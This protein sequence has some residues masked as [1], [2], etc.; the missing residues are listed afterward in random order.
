MKPVE[1]VADGTKYWLSLPDAEQDYIQKTI[2]STQ[3]AY[4]EAMLID[5]ADFIEPG[6]LVLDIG[7]N[8]GN[9][10]LYLSCVAGAE[11]HAFEPDGELCGVIRTSASLN[12]VDGL[13][14]VHEV[15]VGD[16]RGFG[17]LVQ[18]SENNRG[19][20]RLERVSSEDG[21][22]TI[23]RLDDLEF[24]KPV[25]VMKIDVEGM[26]TEVLKGA[27]KLVER[28]RPDIYVECQTRQDFERI[29]RWLIELDY[30]YISTFN[31]T[32]THRF[33]SSSSSHAEDRFEQIVKQQVA[34]TYYDQQLISHLRKNLTEANLKYRGAT[35]QLPPSMNRCA[36]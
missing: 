35:A 32:P 14:T 17:R 20:Q 6:D 33:G 27:R 24:S 29:H 18:T 22:T 11:V 34:A 16:A 31:A 4:E 26:E 15:G 23:I 21:E 36:C 28:Y 5:M 1:I 25:R 30:R 10:S 19:A 9:H 13:V 3:R 7:A 8:C 12:G 2:A